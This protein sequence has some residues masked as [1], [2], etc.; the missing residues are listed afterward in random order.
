MKKTAVEP[1]S[2]KIQKMTINRPVRV[3][4]VAVQA[5]MKK[6]RIRALLTQTLSLKM[7]GHLPLRNNVARKTTTTSLTKMMTRMRKTS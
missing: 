3:L 6:R 7:R 2:K 1:R 5:K 4:M